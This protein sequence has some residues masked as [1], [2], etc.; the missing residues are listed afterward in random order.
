[1]SRFENVIEASGHDGQVSHRL[2]HIPCG[3]CYAVIEYDRGVE[4]SVVSELANEHWKACPGK[5]HARPA[6]MARAPTSPPDT[7]IVLPSPVTSNQR[8]SSNPIAESANSP[9]NTWISLGCERKRRTLEQRKLELEQDEYAKSITTKSVLC[10]GCRKEI[11][12]DK[13]S[14]YY[15]GLWRKHRGKCPDI[16]KLEVSKVRLEN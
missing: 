16:E 5:P 7:A 9:N 11:S 2:Q 8:S 1:M 15:P 10:G 4:W 3:R 14:K 13:R 6:H 12:L